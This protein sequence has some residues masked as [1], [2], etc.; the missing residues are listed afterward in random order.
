MRIILFTNS[1]GLNQFAHSPLLKAGLIV[2]VVAAHHRPEDF[3]ATEL[4]SKKL[5]LP[6]LLQPD[7]HSENYKNF[8]SDLVKL[9]PTH[10]ISNCYSLL[11]HES[12]LALVEHRALNIHWSLLPKNRGP[13]PVQWTLIRGEFETG[14]TLHQITQEFDEGPV[15]HQVREQIEH[16][17]TWV[18]LFAK[19]EKLSSAIIASEKVEMALTK[20]LEGSQQNLTEVT[21]NYRLNE[22]YPRIQFES[23][24]DEQ[25]YNLIRAQVSPLKG[26]FIEIKSERIH[27]PNLMP[28]E[29]IA[30]LREEARKN[31]IQKIKKLVSK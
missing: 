8:E 3:K 22:N 28:L 10:L 23:M 17:D 29:K 18:S 21:K 5:G 4:L 2:G 9:R 15:L 11:I 30:E 1:L 20:V 19:L 26:A 25:I 16:Q 24:S 27:I 12:V 13:N 7:F 14:I 6:L 31:D